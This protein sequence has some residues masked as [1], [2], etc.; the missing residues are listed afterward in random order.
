MQPS[1]NYLAAICQMSFLI[2]KLVNG[3]IVASFFAVFA[4]INY[5]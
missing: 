4:L 2:E 5:S 1:L 3:V